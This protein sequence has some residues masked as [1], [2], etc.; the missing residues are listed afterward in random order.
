MR[1][2]RSFSYRAS[3]FILI[4]ALLM[5][6]FAQPVSAAPASKKIKISKKSV[7]L[8]KGKTVT[9]T[10]KMGNK[11]VS[12]VKWSSSKKSVAT[13]SKKGKVKAVSQGSAVITGKYK[14]KK[15]KCKVTVKPDESK[16][17]ADKDGHVHD[18]NEGE[19][20]KNPNCTT[21][22]TKAYTCKT[23]ST[24][25]RTE[26][27]PALGHS[28]KKIDAVNATCQSE[29]NKAYYMCG[30]CGKLFADEAGSKEITVHDVVIPVNND[31]HV[32]SGW[33]VTKEPTATE[34]GLKER[35]CRVC[36]KVFTEEIPATGKKDEGRETGGEGNKT[37]DTFDEEEDQPMNLS[38]E[39]L[40]EY[41]MPTSSMGYVNR[42]GQDPNNKDKTKMYEITETR[43][44]W[45]SDEAGYYHLPKTA[46]ELAMINRSG[47][48]KGGDVPIEEDDG[49][50]LTAALYFCALKAYT[51]DTA[52]EFDKMM[53]VLCDSSVCKT[54]YSNV[55]AADIR[56]N[57]NGK[58]PA[59]A[60]YKYQYIGNSFFEG[61]T[62][63][64]QYTPSKPMA[65]VVEDFLYKDGTNTSLGLETY[66]IVCR[67]EGSDLD[68]YKIKVYKDP[69]DNQWYIYD[70]YEGFTADVKDPYLTE[71]QVLSA[72]K[73]ANNITDDDFSFEKNNKA[74]TEGKTQPAVKT[75]YVGRE[76]AEHNEETGTDD[77]KPIDIVQ[78]N[79]VLKDVL[80]EDE[81]FDLGELKSIDRTAPV[82]VDEKGWALPDLEK[83][84][85]RFATLAAFFGVLKSYKESGNQMNDK[86][87]EMM[88]EL[89][90]S[91]T[92]TAWLQGGDAYPVVS[93]QNMKEYMEKA[94]I[95]DKPKYTYIANSYFDGASPFNGYTPSDSLSVTVE[96]YVYNGQWSDAMHTYVYTV[97]TRFEGSDTPRLMQMY[98]DPF[99]H[100]WYLNGDHWLKFVSDVKDPILSDDEVLTAYKKSK[101]ITDG[102]FTFDGITFA[103][104]DQ[105]VTDVT[106]VERLA[107]DPNDSS[108]T[109]PQ[110]VYQGSVCFTNSSKSVLPKDAAGVKKISRKGPAQIEKEIN[111]V[112]R[113][114]PDIDHDK[115]RFV[116][117]AEYFAALKAYNQYDYGNSEAMMEEL[118][119]SPTTI[120]LGI[121]VFTNTSRQT[122]KD[123][124]T[125]E[126]PSG[127]PKYSYIGNSYFDGANRINK[128]T[129]DEPLTATVEDYVYD[130][131]WSNTYNTMIYTV[132]SRFA[133]ADTY[134]LLKVYQDPYDL[135]WYIFS[136]SW[137]SFTSDIK[138][139]LAE[140]EEKPR[141]DYDESLQPNVELKDVLRNYTEKNEETG[142][143]EIKVGKFTQ[144]KV[145][146]DKEIADG[147]KLPTTL[148]ELKKLRRTG[149]GVKS[150]KAGFYVTDVDNDDGRFRL[151]ALYLACLKAYDASNSSSVEEVNKMISYLCES[152]LTKALGTTVFTNQGKAAIKGNLSKEQPSGTPK[153]TYIG[154]SYFD[155]A[156]P[157]NGYTPVA[158]TNGNYSIT[159]E[160]YV[161]DGVVSN[162]YN[163]KIYTV[164]T[165]F[166]GAD[167]ERLL[168][169]YQDPF[170]REWYI[171]S[172]SYLGFTADIKEPVKAS[173]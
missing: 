59:G 94:I 81:A 121:D 118:C 172:D 14:G 53:H 58:A 147:K 139:P 25:I 18:W 23:D 96:D 67:T 102:A 153:Y 62:P 164:V 163:L 47:D 168:K 88:K 162:D 32:L 150:D 52:D 45:K 69:A 71:K 120:A 136:D 171:W 131:Q 132:I 117:M 74:L 66:Q 152:P 111:G 125:K 1:M 156:A 127:T 55:N 166:K 5:G 138:T 60:L 42:L 41:I 170:D 70:Q 34:K 87:T 89:T 108:K 116:L 155:G 20:V 24:H 49:R 158:D 27:I 26:V 98:M 146:F 124:L 3:A 44:E 29:G 137:K 92:K 40:K 114:I 129:P 173:E 61:A 46:D 107:Q 8:V 83:D 43:F 133:G 141:T 169:M 57:L 148:E 149:P 101:G 85:G 140:S 157:E 19:T 9:L 82:I 142:E 78:A 99:D 104:A 145:T 73:K 126:Q 76:Y 12:G 122:M 113:K 130:G 51:P 128:Y 123:N 143:D 95:K 31:A 159:I 154:N 2:H 30:R 86:I 37:D 165:K 22:G 17:K 103:D 151:M 97:I 13:V 7:T 33:Q 144:A 72:Y 161:Y 48:R 115:G 39:Q 134:R 64:N 4:L 75:E 10:V 38:D 112:K 6:T 135:Q 35:S 160:D 16:K 80:G 109:V 167:T 106:V 77:V 63:E 54:A 21:P 110:N 119:E 50:F 84:T 100:K 11:K 65:V 68:K 91:P 90:Q 105:P 93:Q 56:V 36:G 28:L 79:V 15:Y